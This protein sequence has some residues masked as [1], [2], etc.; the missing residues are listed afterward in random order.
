MLPDQDQQKNT[1]LKNAGK[2]YLD[3]CGAFEE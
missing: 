2:V 3:T 1:K